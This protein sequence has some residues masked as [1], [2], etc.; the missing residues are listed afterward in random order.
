MFSLYVRKIFNFGNP[1]RNVYTS[2][3][4]FVSIYP[5]KI[6]F[7]AGIQVVKL[8]GNS[9]DKETKHIKDRH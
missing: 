7:M 5:W 8:N 3:H 1:S 2:L 6:I 9:T 4:E